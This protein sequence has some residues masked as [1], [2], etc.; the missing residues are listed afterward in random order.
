MSVNASEAFERTLPVIW[1]VF[2]AEVCGQEE[3]CIEVSKDE[4]L[5]DTTQPYSL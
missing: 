1:V 5:Q 4:I 3:R 2:L